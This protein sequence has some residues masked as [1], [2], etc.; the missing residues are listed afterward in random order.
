M[1]A[2]GWQTPSAGVDIPNSNYIP[3]INATGAAPAALAAL[4]PKS[5][6]DIWI[7]AIKQYG[8]P[9][10]G[11]GMENAALLGLKGDRSSGSYKQPDIDVAG[12]RKKVSIADWLAALSSDPGSMR[13]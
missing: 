12:R 10:L 2:A 6:K 8:V 7:D 9:S 1:I 5:N 3:A 11:K 4:P 13:L